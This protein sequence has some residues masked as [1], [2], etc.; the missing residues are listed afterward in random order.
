[1]SAIRAYSEGYP[2]PSIP[3]ELLLPLYMP[4]LPQAVETALF[5]IMRKGLTNVHRHAGSQKGTLG[6]KYESDQVE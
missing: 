5:R 2:K 1:M 6:L 4:R 3:L